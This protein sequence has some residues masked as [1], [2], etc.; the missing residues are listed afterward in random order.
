MKSGLTCN[1]V[2]ATQLTGYSAEVDGV[3]RE[4]ILIVPVQ[5]NNDTFSIVLRGKMTGKSFSNFESVQLENIAPIV[6]K[7]IL[8]S[9]AGSS[10][11]DNS[12]FALRLKAL[13]E[14]AEIL[15]GVLDID[16]LIPV[17]MER[18]N[19]LLNTERC[20]L[21][22]VDQSKQQLVT[23]F[24]GGLDKAITLPISRGI[25][26]HTATTGNIVNI[27][28]AYSDPRFDQTVDKSTGF[29]TR[30]VLTVPI[31]NNRGEI[32]GVTEMINRRDGSAFDEGDIKMMN[33]FNV[34]CGISLDNA[35]LYKTSLSLTR[36]LRG[37]AEMGSALNN[38]KTVKEILEDILNNAKSVVHASRATI[39]LRDIDLNT[40]T[41]FVSVGDE[42]EHG[43]IFATEVSKLLKPKVFSKDEIITLVK[44]GNS[45]QREQN[46]TPITSS[47]KKA[48]SVE[49][50]LLVTPTRV[51][52]MFWDDNENE[53]F[54]G[55]KDNETYQPICCFPLLTSDS[56]VLGVMELKCNWKVLPED[57]KLLDCFAV[58]AAVSL[59]KS[60]LEEIAKFGQIETALKKWIADDERKT[61]TFPQKLKIP[62]DRIPILD[63][64]NFDAP[65]WDG[66]GLFKV[67]WTIVASYGLLEEFKV[68]NE[69]FFTFLQSISQ[70]YNKVPY[71]NWRHACD[72]TQFVNYEI[73]LAKMDTVFNKF[74]LFGIFVS[75]ICHDANHDGFTNVYNV[76][77]ETPLGILFKNQ[78]VMETHHCAVSIGIVSKEESNIFASLNANDYKTMWTLVIQLILITDMAKHFNFL[79][80][81][82]AELDNGPLDLEN[83]KH[84]LMLMQVILKCADISNVSRPFELADKWCDVLC[85]EFFRQGDLEMA[86]GMEYTSP[87]ND[88]EHLD[89]PKS[90]IGFYTF[91]CLPLYQCAARAMPL[92]QKNV[93]QIQSNLAVW[94][95]AAAKKE[96]ETN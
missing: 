20:S 88:R 89:K 33:A 46:Q 57:M 66:I 63:S 2:D 71:H 94:K 19:S 77:A 82:N 75:S 42:I 29:K 70:T 17:I 44:L 26:G 76:K 95:E 96:Q 15:S 7:S 36:Q 74:E 55:N 61:S 28:D 80:E 16:S 92:L 11:E 86:N 6:G 62:D 24:Q 67:C 91:V 27:N 41:V 5:V 49:S 65:Q 45:P 39:F 56:K 38:S 43:N 18:A 79:K 73:K 72:V 59:E 83:Q 50:S 34:F 23:K 84:R 53:Q 87:N 21:F 32:A 78:S 60:Q 4:P 1:S 8:G 81:L 90:Q 40:I 93:D 64:V 68:N 25:V 22:L 52:S 3:D 69:T 85:E 58:F 9:N 51:S 30:T 12:E 35:K 54:I 37:F 14:V 47:R 13:L 31:Y 10:D 48:D